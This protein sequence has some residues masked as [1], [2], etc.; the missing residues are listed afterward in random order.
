MLAGRPAL[1]HLGL[2]A[3]RFRSHRVL[4]A[5]FE[6][7]FDGPAQEF[8]PQIGFLRVTPMLVDNGTKRFLDNAGPGRV[9]EPASDPQGKAAAVQAIKLRSARERGGKLVQGTDG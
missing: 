2:L 9:R 5:L 1:R 8:K 3:T 7:I 6:Q 4:G